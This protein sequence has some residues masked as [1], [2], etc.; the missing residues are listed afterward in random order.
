MPGNDR[1]FVLRPQSEDVDNRVIRAKPCLSLGK[2]ESL[3]VEI[4]GEV[5]IVVV[6]YLKHDAAL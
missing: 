4:G 2:V 5:E 6:R 3:A 1:T